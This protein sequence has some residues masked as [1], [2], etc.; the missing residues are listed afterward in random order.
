MDDYIQIQWTAANLDEARD[1]IEFLLEEKLISCASIIPLVESWYVW[2]N[3]VVC[4][5]EIKV[6]MKTLSHHYK[7]VESL[8]RKKHSYEIAEILSF[9]IRDGNDKYLKWM[10]D[11]VM[12]K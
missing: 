3:E 5:Q 7:S 4:G 8:I 10:Y 11:Q 6:L 9:S 1:I 12:D 2:E